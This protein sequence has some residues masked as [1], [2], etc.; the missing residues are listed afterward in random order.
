[1]LVRWTFGPASLEVVQERELGVSLYRRG[2][3]ASN[4]MDSQGSRLALGHQVRGQQCSGSTQPSF[5][6]HCHRPSATV[7]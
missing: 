4:A 6:M 3:N 5:A 2:F 1:M 7:A